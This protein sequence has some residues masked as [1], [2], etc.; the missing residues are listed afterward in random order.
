MKSHPV[1]PFEMKDLPF[2]EKFAFHYNDVPSVLD[3]VILHRSRDYFGPCAQHIRITNSK[4]F[5]S[6]IKKKNNKHSK[7]KA[8]MKKMKTYSP[9]LSAL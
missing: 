4:K 3:L 9:L 5:I 7:K 1:Q 8:S 2:N 6:G